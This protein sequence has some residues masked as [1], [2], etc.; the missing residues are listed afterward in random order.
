M[1]IIEFVDKF[2]LPGS[3]ILIDGKSVEL[4]DGGIVEFGEEISPISFFSARG[5]INFGF[6]YQRHG[7]FHYGKKVFPVIQWGSYLV[8]KNGEASQNALRFPDTNKQYSEKLKMF[9]LDYSEDQ[10]SCLVPLTQFNPLVV[11]ELEDF[12][13][14]LAELLL[15]EEKLKGTKKLLAIQI[16]DLENT[17]EM[18]KSIPGLPDHFPGKI[19]RGKLYFTPKSEY[20]P[21]EIGYRVEYKL[22]SNEGKG[23][24]KLCRPIPPLYKPTDDM[25]LTE[26]YQELDRINKTLDA[27]M[28]SY[29]MLTTALHQGQL[30]IPNTPG[31]KHS[32][33]IDKPEDLGLEVRG[34]VTISLKIKN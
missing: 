32:Y 12:H 5:S 11:Q 21:K 13:I 26:L 15:L 1:N 25:T 2:V 31:A 22:T 20:K 19:A 6:R 30:P 4:E 10:E 8:W 27:I 3:I 7:I 14:G 33:P 34:P 28:I 29:F 18:S 23:A 9:G 16:K 17:T 24:A